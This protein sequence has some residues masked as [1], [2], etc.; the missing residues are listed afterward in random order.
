MKRNAFGQLIPASNYIRFAD[1]DGAGAEGGGK[2]DTDADRTFTQ[3]DIDRIV[4]DRASRADR[5]AREDER[6]KFEDYDSL[7]ADAEKFRAAKDEKKTP[8]EKL[9]ERLTAAEQRAQQA[10]DDN[11]K[12]REELLT[13]RVQSAYKSAAT[14]RALNPEAVFAFNPKSFVNDGAVDANAI[15]E[16]VEKN[17]TEAPKGQQRVPG[18]G[19]RDSNATGGSVQSG[20]DLF[21]N[22]KKPSRKD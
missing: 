2:T 6:K 4:A 3:A 19:D 22:E 8:D 13:E 16:W 17:S 21:D 14:G 7:K 1:G 15:K 11:A 9:D 10:A 18:Q 12:L 5:A 20:R